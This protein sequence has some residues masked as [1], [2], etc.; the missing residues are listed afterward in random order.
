[1]AQL[2]VEDAGPNWAPLQGE[3]SRRLAAVTEGFDPSAPLSSRRRRKRAADSRPYA[4]RLPPSSG[5]RDTP[6]ATSLGEGGNSGQPMAVPTREDSLR[7]PAGVTRRLPPPSERE[8]IAD[9]QWPSLRAGTGP[10]CHPEEAKPTKDLGCAGQEPCGKWETTPPSSALRGK[11][12]DTSPCT[13]EVFLPSRNS[14]LFSLFS[15]PSSLF[16]LP[17]SLFPLPFSL[18]L[19][20]SFPLPPLKTKNQKLKTIPLDITPRKG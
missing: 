6:A 7:H 14:L 11:A 2:A 20:S 17:S 9:G 8:A 4:G 19:P 12:D 10:G 16:P 1:M 13:G 3:L 5:G 18:F 15:L